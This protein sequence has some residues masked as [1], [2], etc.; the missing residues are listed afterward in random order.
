MVVQFSICYLFH[1][2]STLRCGYIVI[3]LLIL[4]TFTHLSN[5]PAQSGWVVQ[6]VQDTRA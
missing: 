5:F 6:A 2:L 3:F 1:C 4:F